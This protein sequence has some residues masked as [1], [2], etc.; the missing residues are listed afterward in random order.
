VWFQ[1]VKEVR[2]GL[3]FDPGQP[4]KDGRDVFPAH[5]CGLEKSRT[6]CVSDIDDDAG[7][8][9]HTS[10]TEVEVGTRDACD[11]GF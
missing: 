11:I 5:C 10:P 6:L 4:G 9:A 8:Q 1:L 2:A 7:S 3:P